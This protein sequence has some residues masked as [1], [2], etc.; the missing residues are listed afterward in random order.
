MVGGHFGGV[1]VA[2]SLHWSEART[3]PNSWLFR[4]YQISKPGIETIEECVVE[5]VGGLNRGR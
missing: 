1:V 2:L 4:V 5:I 3:K